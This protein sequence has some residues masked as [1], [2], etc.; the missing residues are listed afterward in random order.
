MSFIKILFWVETN[1]RDEVVP[2]LDA[3]GRGGNENWHAGSK[4]E[5][6]Y[7]QEGG[8]NG[9]WH[10]GQIRHDQGM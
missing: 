2:K 5:A 6:R 3:L 7:P 8:G 1:I 4:P 9:T 10:L